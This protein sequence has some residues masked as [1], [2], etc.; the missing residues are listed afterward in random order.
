MNEK[1]NSKKEWF[2][3]VDW[4]IVS[5]GVGLIGGLM[6]LVYGVIYTYCACN[7]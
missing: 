6:L 2:E 7:S 5:I 4:D 1:E 3:E